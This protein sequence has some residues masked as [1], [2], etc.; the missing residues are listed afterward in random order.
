MGTLG[1]ATGGRSNLLLPFRQLQY[2][3]GASFLALEG[4]GKDLR[5]STSALLTWLAVA[6]PIIPLALTLSYNHAG[7]FPELSVLCTYSPLLCLPPGCTPPC[8]SGYIYS[9]LLGSFFR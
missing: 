5:A 7:W 2:P 9:H 4:V 6:W 8:F 1:H 3:E